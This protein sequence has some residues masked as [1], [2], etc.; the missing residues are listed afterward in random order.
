MYIHL[1]VC[2]LVALPPI[3]WNTV[4]R[5]VAGLFET[6]KTSPEG[7]EIATVFAFSEERRFRKSHD[8]LSSPLFDLCLLPQ[9]GIPCGTE[10]STV[11]IIVILVSEQTVMGYSN[12]IP[13]FIIM[14]GSE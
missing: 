13:V 6:K 2:L 11:G 9:Q 10:F 3:P 8:W 1:H 12:L 7:E 4:L 5:S 14:H